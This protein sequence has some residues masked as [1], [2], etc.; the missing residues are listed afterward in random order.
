[1]G[2]FQIAIASQCVDDVSCVSE[3]VEQMF[4]KAFITQS[5]VE[6]LDKT[7]LHWLA[8]LDVM[9]LKAAGLRHFCVHGTLQTHLS[10]CRPYVGRNSTRLAM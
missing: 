6:A 1:M 9:P 4:V 3:A 2:S 10:T 5:A 7:V 8:W